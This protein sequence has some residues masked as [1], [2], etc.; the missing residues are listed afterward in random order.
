[1]DK[2]KLRAEFLSALMSLGLKFNIPHAELTKLED[3]FFNAT[4]V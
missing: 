2:K 1:M 3:M 4:K